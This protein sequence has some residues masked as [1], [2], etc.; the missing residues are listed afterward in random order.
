MVARVVE[1]VVRLVV[2]AVLV[3]ARVVLETVEVV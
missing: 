1:V 3:E 2:G